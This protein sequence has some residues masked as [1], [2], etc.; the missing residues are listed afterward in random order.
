VVADTQS[1]DNGFDWNTEQYER[2]G[3]THTTVDAIL[4]F[5]P[6]GR[7]LTEFV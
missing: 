2:T 1:S 6:M 7:S 4:K 3:I 5:S